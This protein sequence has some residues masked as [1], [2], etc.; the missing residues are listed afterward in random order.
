MRILRI[1]WYFHDDDDAR[2]YPRGSCRWWWLT[3]MISVPPLFA[4]PVIFAQS[5]AIAPFMYALS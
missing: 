2:H 1:L 5:S 3:P 4:F